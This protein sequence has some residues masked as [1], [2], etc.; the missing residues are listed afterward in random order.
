[1]FGDLNSS[2][3]GFTPSAMISSMDIGIKRLREKLLMGFGS[4]M[5]SKNS[6]NGS[7]Y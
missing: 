5:G 4:S 3:N 7:E 6:N 1:M 2:I